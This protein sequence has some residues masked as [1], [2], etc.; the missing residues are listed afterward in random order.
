MI[1]TFIDQ[2][3]VV[4]IVWESAAARKQCLITYAKQVIDDS[5]STDSLDMFLLFG[6]IFY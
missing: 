6:N 2:I 3:K 1:P 5:Y 4:L